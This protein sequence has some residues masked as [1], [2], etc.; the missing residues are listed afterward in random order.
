MRVSARMHV[1]CT[2]GCGG[3][4]RVGI[5]FSCFLVLFHFLLFSFHGK[6]SH[7]FHPLLTPVPPTSGANWSPLEFTWQS[8]LL[9]QNPSLP[10]LGC[11]SYYK[12]ASKFIVLSCGDCFVISLFIF[13][14]LYQLNEV[15]GGGEAS[16]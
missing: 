12:N 11:G 4:G 14:S 16:N 10:A 9:L 2:Y 6:A 13:E 7:H 15:S 3:R 1:I 5:L 8:L